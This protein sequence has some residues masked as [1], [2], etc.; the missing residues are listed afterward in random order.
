MKVLIVVAHPR[1][2]SLVHSIKSKFEQG[3]VA[4][5]HQ[6]TTLDLFKAGFDPVLREED[7]PRFDQEVQVFSEE[8][9]KEME[10]IN[11]HDAL[12]FAFPMYWSNMPA[13]MKG[14]IDRV[15]NLGYAYAPWGSN[16]MKVNKVFFMTTTGATMALLNEKDHVKFLE[17]YFNEVIA[18][19]CE[20]KKSR[21]QIFDDPFNDELIVN[22][23]LPQ[24]YQE[25]LDFDKW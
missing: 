4:G 21:L 3:L 23:H 7:E 6:V 11:Q 13:I 5:G 20:I 22:K 2:N 17:Y 12:V 25:G 16:T 18:G 10:R 8:I 24:A 14:Y 15:F 9:N 1:E 19:Y